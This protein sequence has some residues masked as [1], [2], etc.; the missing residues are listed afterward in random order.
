[1]R[2]LIAGISELWLAFSG[3]IDRL[4]SMNRKAYS[5]SWR[6]TYRSIREEWAI[7]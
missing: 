2:G 3:E 1:L 6:F 4:T 5:Y 7:V